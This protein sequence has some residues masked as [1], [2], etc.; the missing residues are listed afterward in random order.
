MWECWRYAIFSGKM[1]FTVILSKYLF[2][3]IAIIGSDYG[4]KRF[5]N[6]SGGKQRARVHRC[7]KETELRAA[8]RDRAHQKTRR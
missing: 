3:M 8:E 1:P 6:F 5:S 2:F 7:S 4:T